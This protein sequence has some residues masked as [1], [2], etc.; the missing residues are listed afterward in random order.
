MLHAWRGKHGSI[1]IGVKNFIDDTSCIQPYNVTLAKPHLLCIDVNAIGGPANTDHRHCACRGRNAA[2]VSEDEPL[3]SVFKLF[4]T[5][6]NH[7]LLAYA[8]D[9]TVTGLI[10]LEDVMEELIQVWPLAP[11][12]PDCLV[13][14]SGTIACSHWHVISGWMIAAA[15]LP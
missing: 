15:S 8:E 11:F 6:Y 3:D 10:T 14:T 5:S 7:M 9:S 2:H 4:M 12:M 13:Y 1:A